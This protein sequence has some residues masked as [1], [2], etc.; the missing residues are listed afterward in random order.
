MK[1]LAEVAPAQG[2]TALAAVLRRILAGERG[3]EFLLG[4]LDPI[5]TAIAHETL[6]RLA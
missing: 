1:F 3:G 2:W 4:G 5:D 6:A